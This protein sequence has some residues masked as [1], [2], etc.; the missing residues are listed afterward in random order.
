MGNQLIEEI[1]NRAFI[2]RLIRQDILMSY[3]VMGMTDIQV[4]LNPD[5]Y[6][7]ELPGIIMEILGYSK[8]EIENEIGVA[9]F[10]MIQQVLNTINNNGI[11]KI[12]DLAA[13]VY[14][15]LINRYKPSS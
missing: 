14:F 5:F 1:R 4:N 2:V 6:D 13:D 9:Y 7:F 3:L 11:T 8:E 10:L 12:N 15:Q